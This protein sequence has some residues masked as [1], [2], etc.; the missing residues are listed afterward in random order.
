MA[1]LNL[2]TL[3]AEYQWSKAWNYK[4]SQNILFH[5][6]SHSILFCLLTQTKN[7]SHKSTINNVYW[8]VFNVHVAVLLQQLLGQMPDSK[9]AILLSIAA[10][11]A[12]SSVSFCF[13]CCC[14]LAIIDFRFL[15]SLACFSSA[16]MLTRWF[17]RIV[18]AMFPDSKVAEKFSMARTKTTY[19]INYGLAEFFA[20]CGIIN[21]AFITTVMIMILH[22]GMP[23]D[24]FKMR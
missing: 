22:T 13:F 9:L 12:F 21:F 15:P 5:S 14:R 11:S 2:T 17:T 23:A 10:A 8:L 18:S 3:V 20:T 19:T 1:N 7:Y 4:K 24:I 16:D 6:S